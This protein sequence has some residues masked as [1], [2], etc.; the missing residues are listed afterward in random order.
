MLLYVGV[1]E[2]HAPFPVRVREKGRNFQ[3]AVGPNESYYVFCWTHGA[4]GFSEMLTCDLPLDVKRVCKF[5]EKEKL[6][7][8]ERH[9]KF[10]AMR[11]GEAREYSVFAKVQE[12]NEAY[13]YS[14]RNYE[15]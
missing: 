3:R 13:S 15:L 8:M 7:Y 1:L 10:N 2:T 11:D 4:T 9:I 14:L 12:G 5:E 6:T